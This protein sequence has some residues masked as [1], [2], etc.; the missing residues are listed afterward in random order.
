MTQG[1]NHI[2]LDEDIQDRINLDKEDEGLNAELF[3]Q[4]AQLDEDILDEIKEM[5]LKSEENFEG[6][7][8]GLLR[9]TFQLK[10]IKWL[11]LM[12][13]GIGFFISI[14]IGPFCWPQGRVQEEEKRKDIFPHVQSYLSKIK[15]EENFSSKAS[16]GCLDQIQILCMQQF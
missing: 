2:D 11:T 13:L 3:D 4:E 15:I 7:K 6:A 14:K 5:S 16:F 1:R 10:T 12:G 8:R 9:T